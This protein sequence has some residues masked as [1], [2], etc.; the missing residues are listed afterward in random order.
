MGYLE[1]VFRST[2]EENRREILRAVLLRPGGRMLDLG[3]A[4]GRVTVRVADAARISDVHDIEFI[5]DWTAGARERGVRVAITDLSNRFPYPDEHFDVVHS[6]Q[7]VEHLKHTDHFFREIHRVLKP[8]GYAIVSTNNLASWHN[9]VSLSLG[10][11]PAPSHVSDLVI[12]G[13][14]L[15]GM[16]GA[17]QQVE[18]Q[19]HLRVFTGR[20]MAE[21][22]GYHGLELDHDS[23]AGYYPLPPRI[24][25]V[26]TRLDRRHGAFLVQ[27][28]TR[29]TPVA[30]LGLE[31]VASSS[32]V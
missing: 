20:A 5:D 31:T 13:N 16:D 29:G 17:T 4:D 3:C 11:Q 9:I 23:T 10:L 14:P 22:A 18:G 1:R 24:A 2:E 6:N 7:V 32:A 12:T 15:N 30:S 25:R 26:M 21:L 19:N 28:Y 8:D 27:R